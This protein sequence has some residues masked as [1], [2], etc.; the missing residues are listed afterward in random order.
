M[1]NFF[2]RV[3]MLVTII[4]SV[5]LMAALFG[6]IYAIAALIQS[7]KLM[8]T[9]PIDI[10]KTALDHP[11]RFK[12]AHLLGWLLMVICVAIYPLAFI[13]G[14][15]D[16]LKNGY[17]FL[18]FFV[19][20]LMMLWL[21]KA[22]DIIF[23][24]YYIL[25]KSHFFQHYFPETEGCAGYNQFGFNRKEQLSQIILFPFIALVLAFISTL[26]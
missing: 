14:I 3:Y 17:S 12:G 6:M 19:R 1:R 18:Q 11:E 10:Q 7:K 25:S 23:I 16:G 20:F 15:Y 8:T 2:R 26:L 5:L 9:A 24:D 22:F 21:M 13:Y 4:L